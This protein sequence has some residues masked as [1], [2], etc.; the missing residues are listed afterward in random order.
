MADTTERTILNVAHPHFSQ[1]GGPTFEGE[2]CNSL[3]GGPTCDGNVS[4]ERPVSYGCLT[5]DRE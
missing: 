2:K 3:Y 4:Y 1:C 5:V